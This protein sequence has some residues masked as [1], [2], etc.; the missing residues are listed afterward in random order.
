[1]D[2]PIICEIVSYLN[3][4][5]TILNCLLVNKDL[6]KY[7]KRH[8]EFNISINSL[9]YIE[10]LPRHLKILDLNGIQIS[11]IPNNLPQGLHTLNL[12]CTGVSVIPN[13]LPQGLHTLNLRGT[14]VSVIPNNLPQGLYTLNLYNTI[15]SVIPNN[16]PKG[17]HLIK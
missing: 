3:D 15:V 13:N 12:S 11:V 9:K 6:C 5:R 7:L 2:D 17:L 8:A 1:M 14:E 16:L 10:L 4:K